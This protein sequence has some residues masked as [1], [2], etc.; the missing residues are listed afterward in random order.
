MDCPL[1][2]ANHYYLCRPSYM[3]GGSAVFACIYMYL[4]VLSLSLF[5]T[6]SILTDL[7]PNSELQ[8]QCT[9]N[10]I[11]RMC[12]EYDSLNEAKRVISNIGKY[13]PD[14]TNSGPANWMNAHIQPDLPLQERY[15]R[16]VEYE[17]VRLNTTS[18]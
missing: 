11:D 14:I 5:Q 15:S 3:L 10:E 13:K 1:L 17:P 4:Y 12:D 18:C 6:K 16:F 7:Y 8:L 9:S 2:E